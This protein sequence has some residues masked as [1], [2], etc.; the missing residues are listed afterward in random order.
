MMSYPD[1]ARH[2]LL[3]RGINLGSRNRVA[4]PSSG[5]RNETTVTSLLAPAND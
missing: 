1:M 2:I 4:M 3:L 5:R